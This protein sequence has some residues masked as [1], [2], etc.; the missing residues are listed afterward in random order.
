[1]PAKNT[2]WDHGTPPYPSWIFP[3][4][5]AF[6]RI[7]AVA[8]DFEVRA[9][10]GHVG[11]NARDLMNLFI[12]SIQVNRTESKHLVNQLTIL[13]KVLKVHSEVLH[14]GRSC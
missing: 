12:C 3:I 11:L 6:Q 10:D 14:W 2:Q 8:R 5:S 1:L 13:Q 7:F 4:A 9:K